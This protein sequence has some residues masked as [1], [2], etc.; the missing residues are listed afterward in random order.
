ME[1]HSFRRIAQNYAETVFPQNFHTRKLGEIMEF[2]AVFVAVLINEEMN[3]V[4]H[5]PVIFQTC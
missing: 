5:N 1:R 3:T 4:V 2:Y